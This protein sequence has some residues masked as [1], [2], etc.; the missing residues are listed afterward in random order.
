M[1]RTIKFALYGKPIPQKRHRHNQ[2]KAYNPL[3]VEKKNH[4]FLLRQYTKTIPSL[5]QSLLCGPISV[6]ITFFMRLPETKSCRK[7]KGL[8]HTSRPDIDNLIKF[9]LD[10]MSDVIYADDAYVYKINATKKYSHKE[11]TEVTVQEEVQEL[12]EW[13][14]YNG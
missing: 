3:A 4:Q 9:I 1:G 10:V 5:A 8:Y 6:D 12:I 2:N 11:R 7:T 13:D 14:K